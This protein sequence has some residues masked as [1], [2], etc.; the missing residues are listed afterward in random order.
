MGRMRNWGNTLLYTCTWTTLRRP[1]TS[2]NADIKGR[3]RKVM[4]TMED[5]TFVAFCH[6]LADMF[7]EVSS[8]CLLLQKNDVIHPKTDQKGDKMPLKET[9]N[10][11]HNNRCPPGSRAR[12][13]PAGATSPAGTGA[14]GKCY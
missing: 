12:R 7:Q 6:V 5:S 3:A 9:F 13:E 10:C 4:K 2:N 11:D 14:I 8:L 1:S